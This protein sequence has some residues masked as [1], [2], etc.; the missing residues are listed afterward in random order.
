MLEMEKTDVLVTTIEMARAGL[1][2]NP[3][4]ALDCISD[5]IGQEDPED[6]SHD[7]NVERLLRLGACI[8][9]LRQALLAPG[10]AGTREAAGW[11]R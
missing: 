9:S 11:P 1:G 6:A 4:D 7:R 8:W 3:P 5:L 10:P 2:F